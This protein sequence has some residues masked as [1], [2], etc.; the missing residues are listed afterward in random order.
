MEDDP[1]QSRS[2]VRDIG[3]EIAELAENAT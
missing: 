2:T 1:P 3:L